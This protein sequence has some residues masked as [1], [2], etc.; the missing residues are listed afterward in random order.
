MA[1][2]VLA[3][4]VLAVHF[5]YLGYVV[6]GGFLAWRWP[7]SIWAHLAATAWGVALI[8]LRLDCPLTHAQNWARLRAGQPE[9][10]GGFVD[11]YLAGMIYP[12]SYTPVAQGLVASLVIGSWIGLRA[13]RRP[14]RPAR[15]R[16]R[17]RTR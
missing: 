1:Y 16:S 4:A 14:P 11:Q 9:L 15:S 13:V 10:T 5:A 17:S 8:A 3:A 6:A 2:R 7:R 12:K